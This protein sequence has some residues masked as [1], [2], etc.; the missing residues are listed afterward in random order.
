MLKAAVLE[1]YDRAI[2]AQSLLASHY[3]SHCYYYH[4]YIL[5]II[6]TSAGVLK[7]ILFLHKRGV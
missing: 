4:V 1:M 5:V 7:Q 6:C 3:R 2:Q